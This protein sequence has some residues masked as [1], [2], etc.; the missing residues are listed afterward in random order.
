LKI[1][2]RAESV[3]FAPRGYKNEQKCG[4]FFSFF[5]ESATGNGDEG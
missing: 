1:L 4:F 3:G 2:K 5:E